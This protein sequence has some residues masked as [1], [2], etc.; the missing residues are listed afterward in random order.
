MDEGQ[1]PRKL[2]MFQ[3]CRSERKSFVM[4]VPSS[5]DPDTTYEVK[6]WFTQG[7]MSC[8]CPGFHFRGTC[9]H[10]TIDHEECGW[11][12]LESPEPQTMEQ[13]ANHICPRCGG[14]TENTARG[15]F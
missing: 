4:Q 14:K 9:R 6:G 3:T 1:Q 15:D 2:R 7:E 13:K 12:A 10:L 5:S 11:N 8:T